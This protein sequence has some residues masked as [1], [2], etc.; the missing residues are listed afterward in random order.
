MK[1]IVIA[2]ACGV[3]AGLVCVSVGAISGVNIT[4]AGF[5]WAL[6]NRTLLGFVIGVSALRLHWAW[7]GALMGFLVGS[8]FSYSLWLMGGPAWLLPAVLAG[9]MIFGLGIDFFTTV[10]FK[11]PQ[12]QLAVAEEEI[13][14]RAAA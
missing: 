4:P 6:L 13:V 9:S 10:V 2:T 1:R 7:H 11:Q 14:R 5:G 12:Q 3:V 8:L